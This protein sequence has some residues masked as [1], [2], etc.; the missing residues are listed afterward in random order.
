MNEKYEIP[1]GFG[2]RSNNGYFISLFFLYHFRYAHMLDRLY[3]SMY[4]YN[5]LFFR[6]IHIDHTQFKLEEKTTRS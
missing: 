3:Q 6:T 2:K 4:G 5:N 1:K